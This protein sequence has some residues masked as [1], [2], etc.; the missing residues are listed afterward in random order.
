MT[1]VDDLRRAVTTLKVAVE[2]IR[3]DR[4]LGLEPYE[5][6]YDNAIA[7]ADAA[8]RNPMD[9]KQTFEIGDDFYTAEGAKV[10]LEAITTTGQF[11]VAKLMRYEDYHDS[12]YE[13]YGPTE[14]VDKIFEKPPVEVVDAEIAAKKAELAEIQERHDKA[15]MEI[16]DVERATKARLEKFKKFKGLELLE[17][18]IDK[19]ITHF[20]VATSEHDFDFKI[21]DFNGAIASQDRDAYRDPLR[22]ATLFGRSNGDLQWRVDRY[23][24]GSGGSNQHVWPCRDEQHAKDT[25]TAIILDRLAENFK[26][27]TPDRSYWFLLT[28]EA[29]IKHGVMP[30]SEQKAKYRELKAVSVAGQ[31]VGARKNLDTAQ[32]TLD[33]LLQ[34]QERFPA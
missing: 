33:K 32:T 13:E 8:L 14:V 30:T 16:N 2:H 6:T 18:F 4:R 12:F 10:R 20:V 23:Y 29:A 26:H 5:H 21:V 1:Q 28:Y 9:H 19:K 34:E 27:I 17:D 11:V 3:E 31:I 7:A 24:D 22:L 25:I 15:F